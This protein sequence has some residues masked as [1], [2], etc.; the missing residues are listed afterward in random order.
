LGTKARGARAALAAA[1]CGTLAVAPADR[2]ACAQAVASPAAAS[3][4]YADL[5]VVDRSGEGFVAREL[6]Q[7]RSYPYLDRANRL[8]AQ[9]RRE[10]ARAELEAYLERDPADLKQRY[11]YGVLLASLG[12]ASGAAAQMT[13]VLV[14]RPGFGPALLYRG[15]ARQ[16][17]GDDRGALEDFAA[18]ARSDA[19]TP[20]DRERA[21]ES[22]ANVAVALGDTGAALAALRR[23]DAIAPDPTR[24]L[25]EAQLLVDSGNTDAALAIL[26]RVAASDAPAATRR[27]A[28]S[29]RLVLLSA[30]GR[31]GEARE[32][33]D[34][35]LA[36]APDDGSLLRELAEVARH[37][38]DDAAS[39]AYLERAARLSPGDDVERAEVFA[40][41]R[42]GDTARAASVLRGLLE[43]DPR[44]SA[45]AL[46]DATS[47]AVLEA[48]LGRHDAA[49]TLYEDAYRSSDERDPDLL[50]R[51]GRERAAA[52]RADLAMALF[53]EALDAPATPRARRAKLAEELA[54]LELASGRTA[55]ALRSLDRARRLGLD[56]WSIEQ[57]RGDLLFRDGRFAAALEAYRAAQARRADPRSAL[58]AAYAL[59]ELGKPGLAVGEMQRALD[60]VPPLAPES[61]RAALVSIGFL[62]AQ[63]GQ[64]AEAAAAWSEA[65]RDRLDSDLAVPLAREERLAGDLAAATAALAPLDASALPPAEEAA[66]LDERA[67]IARARAARLAP[68]ARGAGAAGVAGEVSDAERTRLLD[69]AADDLEQGLALDPTPD[70]EYRLGVVYVELDDPAAAIP[71]LERS[72]AGAGPFVP[73]HAAALGYAYQAVGRYEDAGREFA[74]ALAADRD[75]LPLYEDLGNVRVKEVRN[76]DAIRLFEQAI[77][78]TP[79]YPVDD[80]AERAEV[81]ARRLRMRRQ[82]SELSRRF[83][84]LA[85]T[86]ICFGSSNCEVGGAAPLSAGASKSQG[87]VELAVRPPVIGYRDGRVFELIS[88]VLFEQEVNSIVP[89][90]QTTVVT[91]GLRYK[92]LRAIDGYLSA[93]R[94][95]GAGSAAQDNVLLRGTYGWQRGYA[96]QPGV[97]HWSYTTAYVDVART[98][99]SPQDWFFYLEGRQGLTFNFRDDTMLTPHAYLRGRFQTGDDEDFQEVDM[100]LGVVA[101]WLFR[102]DRYHDFQSSAELLP[103]IGYDLVNS[104]GRD[105]TLSLTAIVRF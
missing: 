57:T 98:V 75:L 49:A 29:R 7:S 81:E 44:G 88:R 21:L 9:G 56:S 69:L 78:N 6:R 68:S 4:S 18:A 71:P 63:L 41:E 55:D 85:Y 12:D 90:G 70:R 30:Q 42:A 19:L 103:R 67:E 31:Y 104:D 26:A 65:Q 3:A 83:S 2:P 37:Q 43:R 87:G 72:L 101:R 93:E 66:R 15:D 34:A 27:E 53:R 40:A 76:D 24:G 91:L 46:A 95:F 32:A 102:E 74:R 99:E 54:N 96:I 38:G 58:G 25:M 79:L 50:V 77:D 5:L 39:L 17:L 64:H 11:S 48:K 94:L 23:L 13:T 92:P 80:E 45:R 22:A 16:K 20:A 52:G 51:A 8:I 62:R 89:R 35:A 86:S 14:A 36:L 100:G 97:P 28:L 10:E 59:S 84:L 61:R 1:L 60:G 73:S 47:L 82:V 105:L 33:G